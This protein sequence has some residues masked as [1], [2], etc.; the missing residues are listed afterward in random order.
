[1]GHV[2]LLL[3]MLLAMLKLFLFM[4]IPGLGRQFTYDWLS[5]AARQSFHLIVRLF[6]YGF[7][8]K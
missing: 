2:A 4:L 3:L 1:M 8:I 5:P 7:T 6:Q